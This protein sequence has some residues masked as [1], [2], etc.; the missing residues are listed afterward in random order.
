MSVI[1]AIVAKYEFVE[2]GIDVLAA[3]AVICPEA[4]SSHQ[5]KSPMNPR[6]DNVRGHLADDAR[7]MPIAC[8]TRIGFVPVGEQLAPRFTFAFTKASIEAA[9]LS[10]IMARRMRPERV[11]RYLACLRR[12]LAL[13]VS[14]SITSTAPMTRI[15]PALPLSKKVSPSRKGISA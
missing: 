5:R 13:L 9:E 14:R 8:Q 12:G 10:A 1:S 3:K 6:Q 4:P 11:S 2:I 15:F 7:I